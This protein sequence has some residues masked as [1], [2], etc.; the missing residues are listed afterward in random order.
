MNELKQ[1]IAVPRL[2]LRLWSVTI[3]LR[4]CQLDSLRNLA[5]FFHRPCFVVRPA[6]SIT[7]PAACQIK[8]LLARIRESDWF[9]EVTKGLSPH[10]HTGHPALCSGINI[11]FG[12]VLRGNRRRELAC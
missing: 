5:V 6:K 1:R 12:S 4:W 2:S 10:P 7:N 9:A 11:R 3:V 8:H